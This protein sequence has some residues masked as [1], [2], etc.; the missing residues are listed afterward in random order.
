MAEKVNYSKPKRAID[1]VFIHCSASDNPK[2]DN[3]ETIRQ[4][5]KER[6]WSDIGYHF[7]IDKLGQRFKGRDIEK[8]PAAQVGHNKGSIAICLGGLNNFTELQKGSLVILCEQINKAHN[9]DIT[10]HGHCE[11][12]PKTCPNFD[13]KTLLKLNKGKII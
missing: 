1:R 7:Y 4:W 12:S 3:V 6:G 13:Y 8:I 2:H 5:H 10:F 11:V 9:G